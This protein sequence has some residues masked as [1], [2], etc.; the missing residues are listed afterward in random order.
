MQVGV[1]VY[2]SDFKGLE[3]EREHHGSLCLAKARA[4]RPAN[5]NHEDSGSSKNVGP[6]TWSK[7]TRTSRAWVKVLGMTAPYVQPSDLDTLTRWVRP[8]SPTTILGPGHEAYSPTVFPVVQAP[9]GLAERVFGWFFVEA[10]GTYQGG[11]VTCASCSLQW[12]QKK[13]V[14]S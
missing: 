3:R 9:C 6:K 13:P 14:R 5:P 4:R 12:Q 7:A 11:H 8:P 2:R 10:F 1:Y